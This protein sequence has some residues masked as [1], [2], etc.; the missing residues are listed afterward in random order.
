MYRLSMILL[1]GKNAHRKGHFSDLSNKCK[2][3]MFQDESV[4]KESFFLRAL[5]FLKSRLNV[6]GF[7]YPRVYTSHIIQ[8]LRWPFHVLTRFFFASNSTLRLNQKEILFYI[9]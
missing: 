9:Q 5:R 8:E 1:E 4:V 3:I 2:Y 6:I 7:F